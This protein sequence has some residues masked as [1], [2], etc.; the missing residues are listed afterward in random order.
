MGDGEAKHRGSVSAPS[1]Y[2]SRDSHTSLE[3]LTNT[4]QYAHHNEPS[5][6]IG[7]ES[8]RSLGA[9]GIGFYLSPFDSHLRV[10]QERTTL[11]AA[12][13]DG[14]RVLSK[15]YAT[16]LRSNPKETN[17]NNEMRDSGLTQ[18]TFFP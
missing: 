4:A 12:C 9:F 7:E 8:M 6:H 13:G 5:E 10:H 2:P 17:N 3:A 18:Q 11:R 1:T 15:R 16:D 14:K